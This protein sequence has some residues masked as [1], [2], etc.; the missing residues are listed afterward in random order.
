M[1]C[2]VEIGGLYAW[3]IARKVAFDYCIWPYSVTRRLPEA[4]EIFQF[5]VLTYSPVCL[6]GTARHS[7]T[8]DRRLDVVMLGQQSPVVELRVTLARLWLPFHWF[9]PATRLTRSRFA[10]S[11][12][13]R[14]KLSFFLNG[15]EECH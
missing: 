15:L 5:S 11:F 9:A 6:A 3:R 10:T 7:M 13:L 1:V 4:A 8:V 2:K 12:H 14:W